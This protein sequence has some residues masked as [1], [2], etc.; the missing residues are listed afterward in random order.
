[1]SSPLNRRTAPYVIMNNHTRSPSVAYSARQPDQEQSTNPE[2]TIENLT[3]TRHQDD[4]DVTTTTLFDLVRRAQ[5][6]GFSINRFSG[7]KNQ[8]IF[9]ECIKFYRCK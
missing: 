9:S 6:C 5:V 8:I 4:V 2:N 7:R 3:N 1:M